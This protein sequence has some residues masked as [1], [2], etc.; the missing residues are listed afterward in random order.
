M[1]TDLIILPNSGSFHEMLA[2]K[3]LNTRFQALLFFAV[4]G[5]DQSTRIQILISPQIARTSN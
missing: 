5:D 3:S 4:F 1:S 2:V